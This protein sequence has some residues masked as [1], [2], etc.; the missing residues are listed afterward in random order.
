MGRI[1]QHHGAGPGLHGTLNK[2][3]AIH[4]GARQGKEQRSWLHV[5]RVAGQLADLNLAVSQVKRILGPITNHEDDWPAQGRFIWAD[6]LI[7][8]GGSERAE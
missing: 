8:W 1:F 6:F 2:L 7:R 4:R 3:M 5:T